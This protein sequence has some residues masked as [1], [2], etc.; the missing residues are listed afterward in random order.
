MSSA[1]ISDAVKE[2]TPAFA[3][4]LILPSDSLFHEARMVHNGLIDRKPSL[5]AQCRGVADVADAVKL[6]RKLGLAIAV[7]GGGHN[8]G[9]R[10]TIDGG[11]VIDLSRMKG[12]HVNPKTK[13]ARVEG[14]ALWKEFNRETQVH[15]LATTGG[16]VG[17]TGVGGLT[18][19]GGI[20]WL[21]AKHGLALDNLQS[22]EIVTHDGALVRAS[23]D[24]NPDLF[25]GLRGGG[26]NFGV[27]TSFTFRAHRLD[28]DVFAGTLIYPRDRWAEALRGYVEWTADVPDEMTTLVTFMVPPPDWELGNEVLMFAGFAWAGADRATGEA[29][30]GR[31]RAACPPDVAVVEP[32]RWRAFQSAF[33]AAMPKPSRAYWRNH[34]FARLDDAMLEALVEQ[35]GAQTWVGTAAD[36]HH[37]GGAYGRVAEDATAFPNRAAQFWLNMYGFW[38][39]PADD[40][41]GTAWVKG[42][43]EA[44][45]PFAM[46]GQYVNFLGADAADSRA[47]ALAAYGPAKLERLMALKRRYDPGNLFR[48]NHNIPPAG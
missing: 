6:A 30:L 40:A 32:T 18:L 7:R 23:A 42:V 41:A 2:L 44:M 21:M 31:L 1:A 47:K 24:E 28:H 8:V 33:D 36:L 12:L 38:A 14:G 15:G 19:G 22:V 37:M 26:G 34:S 11:L 9:G 13:L 39:D 29:V 17:S 5:I 35:C 48:I 25:W 45:R 43:S 16:V 20:G 46:A 3:G 27:V 10:G 4:R